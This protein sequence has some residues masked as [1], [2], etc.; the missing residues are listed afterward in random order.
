MLRIAL[1]ALA[2]VVG[3]VAAVAVMGWCLPKGHRA[4]RIIALQAS[5]HDV[6]QVITNVAHA[7]EW[8]SDLE[9]VEQVSGSGVGMTFREVGQNGSVA[10]R[11][12]A[13]EPDRQFVS[14][15]ADSSL[16]Y[17]GRWTFD[18]APRGDGTD[19]TITEDGEVFNPIFRFM[20]RF[21]FSPTGTIERYQADLAKRLRR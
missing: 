17:G 7:A 13:V 4:S 18:L 6:F 2:A 10:Y 3:V 1:F 5:P 11:V 14:A 19:L 12:E 9:R 16:P 20:S 21:V 15:I 8:R